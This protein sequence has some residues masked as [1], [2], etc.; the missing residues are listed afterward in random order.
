MEKI[1][2]AVKDVSIYSVEEIF[3]EIVKVN[4]F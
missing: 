3:R 2:F 4:T 1:T